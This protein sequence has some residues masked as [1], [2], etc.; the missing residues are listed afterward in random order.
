MFGTYFPPEFSITEGNACSIAYIFK[1]QL[2]RQ[3]QKYGLKPGV[4]KQAPMNGL[5]EY[6][7][8]DMIL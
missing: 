5:K 6:H 1:K 2:E 8:I 4:F 7:K 3:L